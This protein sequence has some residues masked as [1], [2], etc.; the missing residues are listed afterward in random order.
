MSG[1]HILSRT[2]SDALIT[3]DATH[4]LAI[5]AM[6]FSQSLVSAI[7]KLGDDR[8]QSQSQLHRRLDSPK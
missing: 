5:C 2:Q 6:P 4:Q 1:K 7:D 3:G 8:E